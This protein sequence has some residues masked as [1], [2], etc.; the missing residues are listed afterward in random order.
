MSK[1][2][3]YLLWYFGAAGA[4]IDL[5]ILWQ[6]SRQMMCALPGA[7]SVSDLVSNSGARLCPG[8]GLDQQQPLT[9]C[10]AS[11]HTSQSQAKLRTDSFKIRA[12]IMF[13]SGFFE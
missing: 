8:P 3:F 5:L 10:L 9:S 11:T 4:C 13:L 7:V 1:T 12:E 2:D 6:I